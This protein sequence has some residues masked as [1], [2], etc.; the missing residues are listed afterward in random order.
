[1]KQW[2]YITGEE[3]D[4]SGA[5]EWA[6]HAVVYKRDRWWL[7]SITPGARCCP[8]YSPTVTG[9]V[10]EHGLGQ[11]LI[12]AKREPAS[13]DEADLRNLTVGVAWLAVPF[14]LAGE[15]QAHAVAHAILEGKL[16]DYGVTWTKPS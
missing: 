14:M 6:T 9:R 13:Y 12:F 8:A 1:M 10:T 16:A 2:K 3:S 4:F 7:E 15:S 5:P 11:M